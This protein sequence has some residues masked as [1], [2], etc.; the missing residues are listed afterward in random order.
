MF[1]GGDRRGSLLAVLAEHAHH[2]RRVGVLAFFSPVEITRPGDVAQ[3]EFLAA[4][5][6]GDGEHGVVG[7][8]GAADDLATGAG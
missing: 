4:Q 8:A 2:G 3:A 7:N 6:E 5:M 1:A